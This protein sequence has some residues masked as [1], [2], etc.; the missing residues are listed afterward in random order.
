MALS[1]C[2]RYRRRVHAELALKNHEALSASPASL[3]LQLR[4]LDSDVARVRSLGTIADRVDMK[5]DELLPK[6]LPT[7]ERYLD[8]GI[9]H[10]NP[11][12]AWCVVWLFDV[13]NFDQALDW[14]DIAIEQGQSTP[15]NIKSTFAT[16][17]A[18][19]VMA[20]AETQASFGHSIEPYFSRT[21]V[22]IRDKWRLHEEVNAKWYKFAGLLLLSDKSGKPVATA[23]D[24]VETLLQADALLAQAGAFD[25]K[26]GVKTHREKIAARIRALQKV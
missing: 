2:Q 21:F 9:V 17:V 23:I 26:V 16:F 15:E 25:V 22:N 24:D 14:A 11:A 20:W 18:D 1:P 10:A 8:S 6:W 13:G 7:V 3:H 12:F 5:R 4:E 19:T